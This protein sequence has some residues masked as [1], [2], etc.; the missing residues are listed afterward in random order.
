MERQEQVATRKKKLPP[1][2]GW[3]WARS[4]QSSSRSR[5]AAIGRSRP[6]KERNFPSLFS[7]SGRS[8]WQAGA[9]QV[10]L[11]NPTSRRLAG[12]GPLR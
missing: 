9:R 4:R 3:I 6:K 7:R 10:L 1:H 12:T 11:A 8:F 2:F 5:F